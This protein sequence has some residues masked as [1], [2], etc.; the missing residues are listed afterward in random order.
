MDIDKLKHQKTYCL[1]KIL[2]FY[3]INAPQILAKLLLISRVLKIGDSD[4][5]ASIFGAFM[6]ER[7]LRSPYS[8]I[9]AN[10]TANQF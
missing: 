9:P 1:T 6:E 5:F 4:I 7:I 8:S 10:V 2:L 3:L